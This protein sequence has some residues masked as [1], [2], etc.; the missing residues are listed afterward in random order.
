M[1]RD[2]LLAFARRDWDAIGR[3]R[4]EYWA[5][6]YARVGGATGRHDAA[7]PRFRYRGRD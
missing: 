4:R 5:E 3:G 7:R 2:D 6:R 1:T